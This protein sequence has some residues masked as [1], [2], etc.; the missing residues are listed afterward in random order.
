MPCN[1]CP[2]G[3]TA[4]QPQALHKP[5]HV[6]RHGAE[7]GRCAN[8]RQPSPTRDVTQALRTL[9]TDHRDERGQRHAV[10]TAVREEGSSRRRR[11]GHTPTEQEVTAAHVVLTIQTIA[12]EKKRRRR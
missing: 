6:N 12:P 7:K 8:H 1:P 10:H 2:W 11:L 3:A 9:S 4:H 5:G